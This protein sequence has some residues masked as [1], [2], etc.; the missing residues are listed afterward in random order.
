MIHAANNA[1]T[2]VLATVLR[3]D[4]LAD[5]DRSAGMT[6]SKIILLPS[7]VIILITI[8]VCYQTRHTSPELT[9]GRLYKENEQIS[10]AKNWLV[11]QN[12]K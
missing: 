11:N 9:P 6:G 7:I 2:Y 8:V 4:L 1:L 5:V 12:K 3:T 10:S